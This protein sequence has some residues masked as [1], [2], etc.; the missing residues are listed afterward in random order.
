[1]V[2]KSWRTYENILL[3]LHRN[4]VQRS[5][6][7]RPAHDSKGTRGLPGRRTSTTNPVR[8]ACSSSTSATLTT[9]ISAST[10]SKSEGHPW[11]HSLFSF[12]P[13]YGSRRGPIP[14]LT[15]RLTAPG[16]PP[17]HVPLQ[18]VTICPGPMIPRTRFQQRPRS[19]GWLSGGRDR[20][21]HH[22]AGRLRIAASRARRRRRSRWWTSPS[23][24]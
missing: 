21:R 10:F 23:E 6:H 22:G 16:R 17:A 13:F 2:A 20:D 3:I 19:S 18:S 4:P 5:E 11:P 9:G 1:M 15:N 12:N 24:S 8:R 14:L 7:R